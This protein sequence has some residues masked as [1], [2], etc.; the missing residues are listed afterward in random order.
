[1]VKTA[2]AAARRRAALAA[3]TL[4]R[5]S[6][7]K[8]TKV[9]K[10]DVRQ[11]Q[12]YLGRSCPHFGKKGVVQFFAPG[13][14]KGTEIS[15]APP[16]FN[17]YAGWAEWENAIFLWVNAVGGS[18][19]NTFRN[20]GSQVSWYV[21]GQKPSEKSPI[22]KRLL[23]K[24]RGEAEQKKTKIILFVRP[25]ATEPYV[26][27]GPCAYVAHNARKKGFEFT[28]K[29]QE[30][31]S[32]KNCADFNQL[33][34]VAKRGGSSAA[35]KWAAVVQ[36]VRPFLEGWRSRL[37][38]WFENDSMRRSV[39]LSLL[40]ANG[41]AV[42]QMNQMT[43][44]NDGIEQEEDWGGGNCGK[45]LCNGKKFLY[46]GNVMAIFDKCIGSSGKWKNEDD[47]VIKPAQT[48][49]RFMCLDCELVLV[50]LDDGDYI[51]R[52]TCKV[53]MPKDE[54]GARPSLLT[55]LLQRL[56]RRRAPKPA[57]VLL[58]ALRLLGLEVN[59]IHQNCVICAAE[60]SG[61]WRLATDFL[62]SAARQRVSPDEI[63]YNTVLSAQE[64]SWK[65][66]KATLE[67]LQSSSCEAS[68]TSYNSLLSACEKCSSWSEALSV[69]SQMIGLSVAL[70]AFS[71]SAGI[72]T[73]NKAKR[74]EEAL[75]RFGVA[76]VGARSVVTFGAALTAC[77]RG[78]QFLK[79]AAETES[80]A[81]SELPTMEL[82]HRK[83]GRKDEKMLEA[84]EVLCRICQ[85]SS[86]KLVRACG[87]KG[88]LAYVHPECLMQ[89]RA[90]SPKAAAE[91]E[92]C[93]CSYTLPGPLGCGQTS[94][95]TL[96]LVALLMIWMSLARDV[97]VVNGSLLPAAKHCNV[98]EFTP[99]WRRAL[100]SLFEAADL[101][102]DGAMSLEEMRALANRTGEKVS[103]AVLEL[104]LKLADH[105]ERGLTLQGLRQTY[106]RDS[107]SVLL[108]DLKIYNLSHV[109][110]HEE[111]DVSGTSCALSFLASALAT[112]EAWQ[113][114]KLS[115][116]MHLQWRRV[117]LQGRTMDWSGVLES[118]SAR[119]NLP[120]ALAVDSESPL[121]RPRGV[122]PGS[123]FIS[124]S[125][126]E[127]PDK[128][129]DV[130]LGGKA[131]K[132]QKESRF[133][134]MGLPRGYDDIVHCR[135][136]SGAVATEQGRPG[137]NKVTVSTRILWLSALQL[138]TRMPATSLQGNVVTYS[139]ALA[140]CA[141]AVQW[142]AACQLFWD[143]ASA[144]VEANTVVFGAATGAFAAADDW[145][146]AI[147]ML[148]TM[149]KEAVRINTVVLLAVLD[150]C[151]SAGK[152]DTI[153]ALSTEM[154]DAGVTID[155]ETCSAIVAACESRQPHRAAM[156][157]DTAG[158]DGLQQL[159]SSGR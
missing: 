108:Q 78:R 153:I 9:L 49:A 42:R 2:P 134:R 94:A 117:A 138:L 18:F 41:L 101:D 146:L 3:L 34:D 135:C 141:D 103:D 148:S 54:D 19:E 11:L 62:G 142:H 23:S 8:S 143:M 61:N 136:H 24:A 1:M 58:S 110:R 122:M 30:F 102:Q 80:L 140:A 100:V 12:R 38:P 37:I 79:S 149:V 50:R 82:R 118:F 7:G 120:C 152:T 63:S 46:F 16:R 33:M 4:G 5:P 157:L 115:P 158:K 133:E 91:C 75:L 125:A 145:K 55:S 70:D 129:L 48:S 124:S 147:S 121:P 20:G 56:V 86:G 144:S 131:G 95:L 132:G 98:G 72:A 10:A 119:Q 87:C 128:E 60:R 13:N 6:T 59:I 151:A 130:E 67:A 85:D 88:T 28:W 126:R 71:E 31:A 114:L 123:H 127:A 116:L 154:A 22:V 27:C 69:L 109:L 68:A 17:K 83:A 112:R 105:N 73:L 93:N 92:L 90:Y 40:L 65:A 39:L 113:L 139:A 89:W 51:C 47:K 76:D 36:L 96:T 25:R 156:L 53:L 14:A 77:E 97:L 81:N 35:A 84:E 104:A 52:E 107:G 43:K 21:G 57:A 106:E 66:A 44:S 26:V 159:Q 15:S 45:A 155:S 137:A 29:L 32:L 74:W 150:A 111:G 99:P 64:S